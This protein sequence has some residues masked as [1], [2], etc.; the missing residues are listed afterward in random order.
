MIIPPWSCKTI[1][2]KQRWFILSRAKSKLAL[3]QCAGGGD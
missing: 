3:G 2:A 1:A